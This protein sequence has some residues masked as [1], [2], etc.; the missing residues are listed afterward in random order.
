MIK[1]PSN[2]CEWCGHDH[3]V[4][5]LC[6]KRP[7]WDRR[8]FLCLMGSA[9]VGA[10]ATQLLPTTTWQEYPVMKGT[11]TGIFI[12]EVELPQVG[13]MAKGRW[14]KIGDIKSGSFQYKRN[15]LDGKDT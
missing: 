1:S 11:P 13:D 2:Q 8:G 14:K 5:A 10:A 7:T 3:D 15:Y 12:F 4:T 6:T 9:I